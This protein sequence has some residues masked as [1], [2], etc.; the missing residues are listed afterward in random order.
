[1]SADAVVATD[2]ASVDADYDNGI[3]LHYTTR[4]RRTHEYAAKRVE[5]SVGEKYRP[6]LIPVADQPEAQGGTK[7]KLSVRV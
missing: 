2:P 3:G 6:D 5:A 7:K 1:M 4:R